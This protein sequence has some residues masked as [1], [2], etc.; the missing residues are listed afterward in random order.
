MPEASCLLQFAPKILYFTFSTYLCSVAL[1][2]MRRYFE[3]R[4]FTYDQLHQVDSF[5][6]PRKE[7]NKV[8]IFLSK[9]LESENIP[10]S[11]KSLKKQQL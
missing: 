8:V 1:H 11:K 6:L 2:A 5:S 10:V 3:H 9:V 7:N 4:F